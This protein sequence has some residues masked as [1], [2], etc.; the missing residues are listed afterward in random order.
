MRTWAAEIAQGLGGARVVVKDAAPGHRQLLDTG[1]SKA[2]LVPSPSVSG[3]GGWDL[4]RRVAETGRP[5][6]SDL[7]TSPGSSSWAVAV[8]A[9]VLRAGRVERVVIVAADPARLSALLRMQPLSGAAFASVADGR[10]RIV[11]RSRDHE[12]FVGTVPPSQSNS[13]IAEQR[14]VFRSRTSYGHEGLYARQGVARAPGWTLVVVEP[15]AAYTASWVHP[16]LGLFGGGVAALALGVMLAATLAGR[17]RRPVAALLRRAE[18]VAA[19]GRSTTAE[20]LPR[21]SVAEFEALR[22]AVERA[23]A[24]RREG[25]AE[26]R[27]AFEQAPVAMSQSDPETGRLLRV[28]AAYCHL[29]G[30]QEPE[31]VGR[32]FLDLVHLED[33]ETDQAGWWRMVRGEAPDHRT[34]KRYVRPDGTVRTAIVSVSPVRG[35]ATGR[36]VRTLA[37]ALDVTE[38]REAEAAL[39]ASEAQLRAVFETTPECVKVVALDGTLLR[40]NRAGLRMVGAEAADMVEGKCVFGLVAPEHRAAWQENHMRV[41]Q[42][43]ALA[44]EF[45]VIGLQGMRRS[46]ET[47]AAPLHLP[48]GGVAQLAVT[49]DV[50]ARRQAEER[51]ALLMREV[52]HRAKNA[53]TVVQATLRLTPKEDAQSYAR[54]VEGRVRAL[55]RAHTLLAEEQWIGVELWALAEGE[56][57]PFLPGAG[58]ANDADMPV[59]PRAEL[60]G[61]PVRLRPEAAQAVA[62]ALHELATNATK[63]GAMSVPGGV[64]GLSWEA[65]RETGWLRLRWE[66][67]GGPVVPGPPLVRGFGSRVLEG[68]IR[69]QLGGRVERRWEPGGLIC[70][71]DLPLTR[72]VQ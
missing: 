33:R 30:R 2:A 66:E 21:S 31:L 12:R 65:D 15:L 42:G 52:D 1:L 8:A 68:T 51:Q 43:E 55:A 27:T 3:H 47:H 18:D 72:V 34:E 69:D 71:L 50:T 57:A 54:A 17:V 39:A 37:A 56:L 14:G 11:A 23:E 10:G 22:A 26:F 9:P 29:L 40:M 63:H 70:E 19:A 38:R 32:R 36:V 45:D 59:A 53:L 46:M 20:P 5:A 24:A 16:L 35:P 61:P 67:I 60:S 25:E 4:I 6:V 41:C 28:N 48:D 13:G 44:W 7:F 62:M 58:N 64:V 49:R